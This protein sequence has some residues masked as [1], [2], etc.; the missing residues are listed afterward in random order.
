MINSQRAPLALFY[1]WRPACEQAIAAKMDARGSSV[2]VGALAQDSN[3]QFVHFSTFTFRVPLNPVQVPISSKPQL[4][5]EAQ[6][7][8]RTLVQEKGGRYEELPVELETWRVY[9]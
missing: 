9:L 6:T 2:V 8:L 7:V 5:Q 1:T 3:G 4:L